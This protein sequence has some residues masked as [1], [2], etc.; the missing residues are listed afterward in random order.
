MRVVA[1]RMGFAGDVLFST[2]A[3][4][5]IKRKYPRAHL[6]YG[7]WKQ[8][9]NL[10][11]LDPHIDDWAHND[12]DLDR[13]KKKADRT[14]EISHEKYSMPPGEMAYWGEI[15]A[16][17]AAELDLLR[18]EDM[19]S[20]KPRIYLSTD[21]I[22]PKP[23]GAKVAALGVFSKNGADARLWGVTRSVDSSLG[24]PKGE[25]MLN[26]R[27]TELVEGLRKMG[28]TCV[29]LGGDEDP[30]VRGAIDLCGQLTWRQSVGLVM[31]ADV[32]ITIDSFL[33]HASVA[34][35]RTTDGSVLSEGTPTVALLGPTDSRAMFPTDSERVVEV[36]ARPHACC[37]HSSRFGRGPCEHGNACL[38]D[39]TVGM[40]L[41]G[42]EKALN[43]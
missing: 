32:C 11:L 5:G 26:Y 13:A 35:K 30:R 24:V 25:L 36:Q 1:W 31:Q 19:D 42:V 20:F 12:K 4:E 7:V 39:I 2:A 33:L 22:I 29:Q 27:W 9:A 16:R 21:D 6:T 10:I 17:Q 43:D 38:K 14:W 23:D 40:V 15:H 28:F 37:Y 34:E 8:Y 3:L 18:L 41:E